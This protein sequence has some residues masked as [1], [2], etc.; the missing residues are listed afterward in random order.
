MPRHVRNQLLEDNWEDLQREIYF[1]SMKYPKDVRDEMADYLRLAS[2]EVAP[3]WNPDSSTFMSWMRMKLEWA[4][5]D[6][7]REGNW[8]RSTKSRI[9]EM[10][11]L[12]DIGSTDDGEPVTWSELIPDQSPDSCEHIYTK[13]LLAAIADLPDRERIAL[14]AEDWREA[15]SKLGG[16][17]NSSVVALRE[18]G[19]SRLEEKGF[20]TTSR[21]VE[22]AGAETPA[23]DE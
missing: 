13:D 14:V 9:I 4:A 23:L 12:E 20:F 8:R 17:S 7:S 2:V 3:T 16:I 19:M 1:I 22:Y 6:K 21:R 11:S 5:L 18:K 10:V 15:S